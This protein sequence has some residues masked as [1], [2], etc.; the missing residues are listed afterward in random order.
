MNEVNIIIA[1]ALSF[2]GNMIITIIAITKLVVALESRLTR[3][4][5]ILKINSKNLGEINYE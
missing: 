2:I 5:T 4:E 3:I 1:I